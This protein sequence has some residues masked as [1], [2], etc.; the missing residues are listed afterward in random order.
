MAMV[1][2][3]AL[4]RGLADFR[5]A[6][7][8]GSW[9]AAGGAMG[10]LV[11]EALGLGGRTEEWA[12][13][14]ELLIKVGLWFAI[15]GALIAIAILFG[16]EKYRG[17]PFSVAALAPT[18]RHLSFG[19]AFG[20]LNGFVAGVAAQALY[21]GT[22]PTE[23]LRVICWGIAGGLLGFALSFRIPNLSRTRGFAG[24]LAGGIVGGIVFIGITAIGSQSF[25]RLLGVA[26][27]GFAIGLMIIFADALFREAWLEVRYGPREA[28]TLIGR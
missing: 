22:G 21:T 13:F 10:A 25:G 11:G 8:F 3:S 23:V 15:I 4:R 14:G 18:A 2:T 28:R 6:L 7:N 5:K 26:A 19:A 1:P 16:H 20:A 17:R 12:Q 27:I 24:G 9:G